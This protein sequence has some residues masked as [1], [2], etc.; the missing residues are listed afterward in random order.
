MIRFIV[1]TCLVVS[2][3]TSL[4]SQEGARARGRVVLFSGVPVE[5]ATVKFYLLDSTRGLPSKET[6]VRQVQ[7]APDGRFIADGLPFGQYRVEVELF[8]FGRT[9]V[10]RFYLW[11]GADRVLDIGLP[12]GMQHGLEVATVLGTVKGD[13]GD[14]LPDATVTLVAAYNLME[15]SQVRTDGNGR[16]ELTTIQPG[17]YVLWAAKDGWRASAVS[18]H[19]GSGAKQTI[20]VTLARSR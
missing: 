2:A 5:G 16:F 7:S 3:G 14:L 1:A 17:E 10:W 18:F 8:G 20:T 11:R 15:S 9:E 13:K 4:I 6:L 12:Q 19:L